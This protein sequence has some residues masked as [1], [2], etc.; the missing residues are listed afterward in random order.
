MTGWMLETLVASTLLMALVMLLRI[1]VARFFGARATYLLWALPFLRLLLP[2][3]PT[4]GGVAAVLP[5]GFAPGSALIVVHGAIDP[6][7]AQNSGFPWLEAGVTLWLG[8][9]MIFGVVQCLGY[10]RFRRMLLSDG[11][12]LGREGRVTV[13]ETSHASGPLAFGVL[14][15]YVALPVDFADRYDADERAMALAHEHGHHQ[16]HDLAANMLALA[17]LGLHWWNPVAWI[18]YRA[19]RADQELACDALVLAHYGPAHS[20]AYGR[21]ILKAAS[22]GHFAAA[23]HLNTIDNLKGRLKMLTAHSK[24]LHRITWGMTVIAVVTAAGLALTASG[25]RAAQQVATISQSVRSLPIARLAS[26]MPVTPRVPGAP[27]VAEASDIPEAPVASVVP[28]APREPMAIHRHV[29]TSTH[30]D[31]DLAMPTIPPVPPMPPQAAWQNDIPTADQINAM[32]PRIDVEQRCGGGGPVTTETTTGENG[33]PQRVRIMICEKE[34]ALRARK[35]ALQSLQQAR[36]GVA[37]SQ[38]G[39]DRAMSEKIRAEVLADLD[40][41]IARLRSHED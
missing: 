23:C 2:P 15:P 21:A 34:V 5:T 12:Y 33:R 30:S 36:A 40:K 14:H 13:I 16:R 10:F 32:I 37:T 27:P 4:G 24:S 26:F 18:A 8:G 20:Q 22:G 9:A 6:A 35:T 1:P 38:M 31:H 25:P 19:F 39:R 17:M 11:A 41:E 28:Q 7:L 29:S 3:L